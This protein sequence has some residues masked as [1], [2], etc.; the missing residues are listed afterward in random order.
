[1]TFPRFSFE[2]AKNGIPGVRLRHAA[3]GAI[4]NQ[5][6]NPP[7]PTLHYIMASFS[8]TGKESERGTNAARTPSADRD[9][10]TFGGALTE[11][12]LMKA[13][14]AVARMVASVRK[15]LDRLDRV[16]GG[17]RRAVEARYENLDRAMARSL[18]ALKAAA[19][20]CAGG[21]E[22]LSPPPLPEVAVL[23]AGAYR[24]EKE[25]VEADEERD[26][27]MRSAVDTGDFNCAIF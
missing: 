26:R 22:T 10:G 25:L 1:M 8:E 9:S 23:L 27:L 4:R 16:Y 19:T 2:M 6:R 20:R 5:Y 13:H 7:K 18:V 24:L 12:S 17:G 3:F 11:K 21:E 15:S 14:R